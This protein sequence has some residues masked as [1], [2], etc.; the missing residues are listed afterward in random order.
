MENNIPP[1]HDNQPIEQPSI[2]P[3]Y[4]TQSYEPPATSWPTV[5]GIISIIFGS[6]GALSSVWQSAAP[7]LINT[8]SK[9]EQMEAD[10]EAV[11]ALEGVAQWQYPLL[12][13][14]LLGLALS[15]LLI[16]CGA[17]LVGRNRMASPVF[18]KWAIAKIIYSL[19]AVTIGTLAQMQQF[20]TAMDQQGANTGGMPVPVESIMVFVMVFAIV[21]GLLFACAYPVFILVWFGREKVRNEV[22]SWA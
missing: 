7:F 13:V 19:V 17:K 8:I 2:P 20:E 11:K 3:S 18:K 5:I 22:E 21:F 14:G 10:P 4:Q 12:V 9:M 1:M 16:V 6:L 15:V